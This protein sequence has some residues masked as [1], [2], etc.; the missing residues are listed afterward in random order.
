MLA[1][2]A[3]AP[4]AVVSRAAVRCDAPVMSEAA[5]SRY[6][7]IPLEVVGP[8]PSN[9]DVAGDRPEAVAM[10]CPTREVAAVATDVGVVHAP[11]RFLP[12]R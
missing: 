8:R 5:P 9:L 12:P 3:F 10:P 6:V 1:P 11:A 2:V 4:Q 7:A